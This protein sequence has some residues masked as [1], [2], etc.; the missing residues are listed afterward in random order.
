MEE[1]NIP[2]HETKLRKVKK[3]L[4][5]NVLVLDRRPIDGVL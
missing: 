3:T 5:E 1:D 4:A 2:I